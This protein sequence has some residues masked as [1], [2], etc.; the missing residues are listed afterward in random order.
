VRFVSLP[1]MKNL[2][3]GHKLASM[4]PQQ[5]QQ[6]AVKKS[7]IEGSLALRRQSKRRQSRSALHMKDTSLSWEAEC[8]RQPSSEKNA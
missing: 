2:V 5:E 4:K 3:C 6:E 7:L 1:A 8:K